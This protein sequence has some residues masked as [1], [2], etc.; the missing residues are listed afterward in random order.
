MA[1]WTTLSPTLHLAGK[2]ANQGFGLAKEIAGL[3]KSVLSESLINS[4]QRP[5]IVL[6]V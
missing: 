2:Q 1:M 5:L 3:M 6:I 4:L